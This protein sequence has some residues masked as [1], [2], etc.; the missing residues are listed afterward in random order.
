MGGHS[1]SP[2]LRASFCSRNVN[3]V[4]TPNFTLVTLFLISIFHAAFGL[5]HINFTAKIE[6]YF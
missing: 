6:L 4:K 2:K 3:V 1:K 5:S